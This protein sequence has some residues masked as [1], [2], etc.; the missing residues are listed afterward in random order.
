MGG[1]SSLGALTVFLVAAVVTAGVSPWIIGAMQR[2]S[3]VDHEGNRTSHRGTI[4]RGGG[5][6]ILVGTMVA[7]TATYD[8]WIDQ[9]PIDL[10]ALFALAF[11]ILGLIDDFR[12]LPALLRLSC[13]SVLTGLFLAFSGVD[14]IT[15]SATLSIV[16]SALWIMGFVNAF[17]F[18]DGI[19]GISSATT[20]I[21]GS[22]L[23]LASWRWDG[24]VELPALALVG[25][26]IG[27]APFNALTG[28]V[29]LGDVGS[30]LLGSALALLA[31][32]AV[33][34][35]VPALP[36]FLPF[37][38]YIADVAYTMAM[39][40]YRR[41][42]ILKSHRQHV[43]QR[44][45]NVHGWSHPRTALVVA[46]FTLALVSLGQLAAGA[47]PAAQVAAGVVGI[48]LVV[49]YLSLPR[50]FATRPTLSARSA[51]PAY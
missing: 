21:I 46:A 44:L 8:Q 48:V 11:G 4:P 2:W 18:M 35:G 50:L 25:G 13:Q 24:G 19:N 20:V 36:V 31:V 38:V 6:A 10:V 5:V 3:V 51:D 39:R 27:F 45:T 47:P 40:A 14:L 37:L 34:N 7:L 26:A 9:P 17:N 29:F 32:A 22:S 30:Y 28:R 33:A 41:E 49:S 1:T 12:T 23:A 42:Q 43:Y 16:L 15:A